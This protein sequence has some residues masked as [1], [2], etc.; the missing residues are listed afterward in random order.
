M[1]YLL[2]AIGVL[3]AL[4]LLFVFLVAPGRGGR[5]QQGSFAHRGLYAENQ[6]PPENSIPAFCAAVQAGYGIELDVN[7]TAD[8]KIV[9]FHDNDL[10]RMCGLKKKI[11]ECTFE[12]LQS[13]PLFGTAERIPL[14]EE[15]LRTVAGRVPLIVEL[16]ACPRWRRLCELTEGMLRNYGGAYCVESFL[17][18]IVRWFKK[19]AKDFTRG[20]LAQAA[21]EYKGMAPAI[22]FA[23]ANLLTNVLSRPHFVAYQLKDAAGC[24][25][26]WLYRG[27]GGGAVTWTV[28][29]KDYV[30][31]KESFPCLIFEWF[32]PDGERLK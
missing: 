3:A 21:A 6:R 16:K 20:Q 17:P 28:H 24:V 9:V 29:E 22:R 19:N 12:E 32:L 2:F 25:P 31:A 5:V 11:G 18:F 30:R 27:L 13:L 26:L 1:L 10:E 23:A 7:I 15:V 4:F 8:D 14:F